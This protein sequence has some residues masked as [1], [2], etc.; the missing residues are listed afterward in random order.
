MVPIP[1][2]PKIWH[3]AI[4]KALVVEVLVLSLLAIVGFS[5]GGKP[6]G[7]VIYTLIALATVAMGIQGAAV[8]ALGVS[9]I[10]TTY[11][12]GTWTGLISNLVRQHHPT[13]GS[14]KR[15]E[16]KLQAAVLIVY[17]LAANAGGMAVTNWLVKSCYYPGD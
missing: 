1:V 6:T 11:I 17:V 4:T 16:T 2:P 5:A 7:H 3:T 14:V 15:V 12:T 9:D 10:S 13:S 8:R